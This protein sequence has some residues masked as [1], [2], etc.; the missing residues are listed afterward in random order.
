[1]KGICYIIAAGPVDKLTLEPT[2]QDFV[3]AAD[4]GYLY[5]ADLATVA[6]LVVGDFDS[7]EDKPR[8]PNIIEHPVEKD[9]T[10]TMLAIDE[11]LSR[12]FQTF[13]IL[14]GLGGRLDHTYA[15]IQSLTY[16]AQ[17]GA[18]GYLLGGGTVVTAIR[19]DHISFDV[20]KCGLISVFCS[21]ENARGVTLKGLKYPL[22]NAT[23]NAGAPLGVS[24]AFT[25]LP[26]EISVTCGTL[27]VM[28]EDNAADWIDTLKD[29]SFTL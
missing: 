21:G 26:S 25:G 6:D 17:K 15:N 14:G 29:G 8:H 4:A 19:N 12:G 20:D 18:R 10:D 9:E 13:A 1:M 23:L 16:I 2:A 22:M 24:N 11:G 7:L 5:L 27:T 28:W 3:I